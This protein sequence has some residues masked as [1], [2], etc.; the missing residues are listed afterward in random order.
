MTSDPSPE[1]RPDEAPDPGLAS[2]NRRLRLGVVLAVAAVVLL[3]LAG[4]AD[5]WQALGL[6]LFTVLLPALAFAQLPLLEK[7]SIRRVSVYLGSGATILSVGAAAVA[8]GWL[9]GGGALPALRPLSFTQTL[10]WTSGAAGVSLA[11]I[12]ASRDLGRGPEGRAMD[13][14]LR[15]I[16]RTPRERRL[17]VGLSIV[18]GLGEEIAYRGFTLTTL[19]LLGLGPWAAAL[20]SSAAFG[21]LHAYQGPVGILRTAL[22]GLLLAVSVLLTG[23][24]I[25]AIVSHALID[26]VAG[27]VIG[28]RMVAEAEAS[29]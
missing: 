10:L 23:S 26:I 25:P 28:P 13:F 1:P 27:L 4:A 16:P 19:Q 9:S 6:S 18:A 8:L 5:F 29:P 22:I 3:S 14:V 7:A 24:L 15:L 21:M 17:F 2:A 20:I 12:G 11:L